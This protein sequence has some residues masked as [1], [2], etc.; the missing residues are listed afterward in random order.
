[1][2]SNK[3]QSSTLQKGFTLVEVMVALLIVAVALPALLMRIGGMATAAHQSRDTAV[4]YWVA[5]NKLQDIYITQALQNTVPRGRQSDTVEMANQK[6]EWIT[7]T[8]ET[9]LPGVLRIRVSVKILDS[10]NNLV[11][12]SG[13][14][15]E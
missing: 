5:E 14:F 2:T 3:R 9:A 6:W 7:D 1:M 8:E 15:V 11:E 12:L 13:F 10:E 4:A